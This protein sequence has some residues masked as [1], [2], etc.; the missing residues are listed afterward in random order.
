MVLGVSFLISS[1]VHGN[2]CIL[3]IQDD[4]GR[5]MPIPSVLFEDVDQRCSAYWRAKL[6]DDGNVTLWPEE[7]YSPYFHDKLSDGD[8]ETRQVFQSV[9]SKM[10]AEFRAENDIGGISAGANHHYDAE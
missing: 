1:P 4:A 2:A 9:L 10:K 3:D 6:G 8:N 7:F 5:C